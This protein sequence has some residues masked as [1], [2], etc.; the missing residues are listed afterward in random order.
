MPR[1]RYIIASLVFL[2]ALL[3][4][5]Q[6]KPKT[7]E[8]TELK[9]IT[10]A[11]SPYQR[12]Y[13]H[14]QV[15]KSK[16]HEVIQEWKNNILGEYGLDA[17]SFIPLF[18][19]KTNFLPA[20]KK[21]APELLEEVRGIADGSGIDF[22][23][24]FVYQLLDE[25]WINGYDIANS[26]DMM[27]WFTQKNTQGHCSTIGIRKHGKV[28]TIVGQT[29]DIDRFYDGYQTVLRIK[30]ENSDLEV[31]TFT[32]AGMLPSP[33]MN[34]YGVAVTF[35]NLPQLA[36]KTHG[37]PTAFII[38]KLLSKKTKQEAI[39]FLLQVPHA[40]GM[41]YMI[42]DPSGV[43]DFECSSNKV[44][45]YVWNWSS[46]PNP[47]EIFHTNHPLI[48]S[49]YHKKS[50]YGGSF[51]WFRFNM[52]ED[53]FDKKGR[54]INE[55]DVIEILNK[56]PIRNLATFGTVIMLL[57]EKPEFKVKPSHRSVETYQIIP[58]TATPGS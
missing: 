57:S 28:P 34:N 55:I 51:S 20:I 33:G 46:N 16:I 45:E 10:L 36:H 12:G 42:S 29:W 38:P 25:V 11:G 14:G 8:K 6:Y 19:Q 49:D 24:I 13:T 35:N 7:I 1:L 43:S 54:D 9:I 39:N 52:I 27:R 48:N 2:L 21:W 22:N 58:F 30:Y 5:F 47:I 3:S 15:L 53:E 32:V 4:Y 23:T 18:M 31:L 56:T 17:H 40:S 50:V 41:N 37:V 44:V 26:Y